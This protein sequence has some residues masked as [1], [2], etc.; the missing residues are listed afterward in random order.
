LL[1]TPEVGAKV[2]IHKLSP[3]LKDVIFL[4][5]PGAIADN[6]VLYMCAD[7][8]TTPT[9]LGDWMNRKIIL[10]SSKDH[11]ESWDYVGPLT[12]GQDAKDFGYAALTGS[13]LVRDKDK[14][15]L[16]ITPSGSS[17]KKN[18]GHDGTI[19]AEIADITKAEL[20]RDEKGHIKPVNY[21]PPK[22]T[23]GGLADY[24]EQNTNGGIIMPQ[25]NLETLPVV[26]QVL[27]TGEGIQPATAQPGQ[28]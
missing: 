10:L 25:I 15:Y 23:M 3:A 28:Q 1:G 16:L 12:T 26:F 14:L 27:S 24:H 7:I 13:S 8:C 2:D 4:M 6:G 20:V 9:S 18:R 5:E 11:G 17:S 21:L 19:I 22:F